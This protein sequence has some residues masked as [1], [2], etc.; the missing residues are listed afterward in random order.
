M[1]L[2]APTRILV[3]GLV[4]CTAGAL[5]AADEKKRKANFTV[6]KETTYVTGPLDKD[7]YVDYAAALNERLGKGVTPDTNANVLIW[8]ALGPKPEGKRMPTE[9]YKLMGM[10]EPPEKGDYF[11]DLPTFLRERLKVEDRAEL[12]KT[13]GELTGAMRRPWAAKD[14]PQIAAW[15]E[16]NGK[17]LDLVAEGVKRPRYFFPRVPAD[18]KNGLPDVTATLL[19]G[20]QKDRAITQALAARA[21][22]RL[23]DGTADAAWHDLLACHRLGRHVARGGTLIEGL[24]GIAL[25]SIA[26]R[27]AAVL[28]ERPEL[29]A[30]SYQGYLA[31][32][33]AL[34]PMPTLADHLDGGERFFALASLLQADRQGLRQLLDGAVAG[35]RAGL[36]D[37]EKVPAGPV[38]NVNWDPAL[39]AVNRL[40]DRMAAAS[41]EPDR[42]ARET[43]FDRIDA[44]MKALQKGLA[45]S[46]DLARAF[47]GEGMAPDVRGKLLGEFVTSQAAAVIR[48][49]Q[50]ACDLNEQGLRNLRVALALAAY[51]RDHGTYPKSLDALA[52][53]Y[54]AKVPD[55]LFAGK[56][57]AYQPAEN[58]YLLYSVGPNGKDDGG[59]SRGD[60]PPGDDIS[61]RIPLPRK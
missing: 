33:R 4:A 40:F 48:P 12:N 23:H 35:P 36:P 56:P 20:I 38:E 1:T 24:V 14:H 37:N 52:P 10:E 34:P 41:R 3:L 42:G 30:K 22:L 5:S 2:P 29:T 31:D 16:G 51:E 18:G 11:V 21:M 58:G 9:F 8:K 53:K 60:N 54:L 19:P 43:E 6:S 55:D 28:L 32:L 39:R 17:P 44:E 27:A 13:N 45:G 15:L 25:E 61:V 49:I 26:Q 46:A 59:R 47:T 7:G 50:R 57:L